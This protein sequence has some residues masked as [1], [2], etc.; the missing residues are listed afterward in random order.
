MIK[1]WI[2]ALLNISLVLHLQ[3]QS[4]PTIATCDGNQTI[5]L[6][7]STYDMCV[8]IEVKPGLPAPIERFEID[9]GD[10]SPITMIP[11]SNMPPETTHTFNFESFFQTCSAQE[12]STILLETFLENGDVVNNAFVAT[13][14]NPPTARF[15]PVQSTIC[16]GEEAVFTDSS[17]PTENLEILSWDY[18]DGSSGAE[19]THLYTAIGTY[20]V[21]LTVQNGCEVATTTRTIEVIEEAVAVALPLTGV[22]SVKNDTLIVCLG[23]GN[24]VMLDGDS[25]SLNELTHNWRTLSSGTTWVT[26]D[27]IPDPTIRFNQAG[28]FQIELMVNNNCDQPKRDTLIFNVVDAAGFTL[29]QQADEC[30]SLSYTPDPM[31]PNVTYLINGNITTN[32][33]VDLSIGEYIIEANNPDNLCGDKIKRDTF[34]I[35]APETAQINTPDTV[36]CSISDPIALSAQTIPGAQWQ[37]NGIVFDG[38]ID[39]A[40]LPSGQNIITY[41]LAPCIAEDTLLIEVLDVSIAF[42]GPAQFCLD[43][44]PQQLSATPAGGQWRGAGVSPDGIFD[45]TQI[46]E[47]LHTVYYDISHPT[48]SSCSNSDS[49][50]IL[51]SDLFVDFTTLDCNGTSLTFDTLLTS[52]FSE[53]EWSFGDG[54]TSNAVSP[55]H[56]FP[57]AQSY[58]VSLTI[59][60]NGCEATSSRTITIS[61]PPRPQFTLDYTG[62]CSPLAVTI[63]NASTG[64][65]LQ[66]SWDFGNG[67]SSDTADPGPLLLEAFGKDTVYQIQL[68]LSNDCA[69][70]IHTDS[71]QV[72]AQALARF[73]TAFNSYCSGD[74]IR[75]S[76]NSLGDPDFYQWVVNGQ[77]VGMD[78]LPPKFVHYTDTEENIEICQI[79]ENSCGRDTLCRTLLIRPTDVNSFF[80]VDQTEVCAG[81]SLRFTNFSNTNSVLYQFGDGNRTSELN[82]V[83]TYQ[84]PGDYRVVLQAYGCGSDSSFADIRVIPSPQA[85]FIAP[86]RLCPDQEFQ[87]ENSSD[88]SDFRWF[89]NDSLQSQLAQP[90]LK[91]DTPGLYQLRLAVSNLAGCVRTLSQDIEVVPLPDVQIEVDADSICAGNSVQ[92]SSMTNG[93]GCVWDFG[94]GSGSSDCNP[95]ISYD[96][97]GLQTIKLLVNSDLACRDSAI[98][99]IFVRSSPEVD[100]TFDSTMLCAPTDITF[101]NQTVEGE[102]FFWEFGDGSTSAAENPIHLYEDAGTYDVR[103]T[104][105]K[106]GICAVTLQKSITIA[107]IPTALISLNDSIGCHPFTGT[108]NIENPDDAI[109]YEWNFGDG[110]FAFETMTEHLYPSSGSYMVA[111]LLTNRS[112]GC[113]DTLFQEIEVNEIPAITEALSHNHCFED[114]T[115][116]ID[117]TISGG[118]APY[119]YNW[120]DGTTSEDR[121]DLSTGSYSLLITD[122]NGCSLRDT[123]IIHAPAELIP[124][125]VTD[126]PATCAGDEDG[127]LEISMSGGEGPYQLNWSNGSSGEVLTDAP[128]GSYELSIT[129]AI[130]CLKV[131]SFI[132]RE[133]PALQ[134]VDTVQPIRCFG[135]YAAIILRP[136]GGIGPYEAWLEP[137]MTILHGSNF[138]FD[139]LTGGAYQIQILDSMGCQIARD[140][141]IN[142]PS[143]VE[144]EILPTQEEVQLGD[145]LYLTIVHNVANP[146]ISWG[147]EVSEL[148]VS[149]PESPLLKPTDDRTYTVSIVNENGCTAS[150]EVSIRVIKDRQV[151][152]PNAFSPNG[153]SHNDEFRIFACQGVVRI[154]KV[155]IF[156][157][158]G[159]L[160]FE[161]S[162]IDPV[163]EVGT[164][165]WD[166][167]L[168]SRKVNSGVFVYKVT[169]EYIDGLEETY[170]GDVSLVR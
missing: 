66:Y 21:A 22:S 42:T 75:M 52:S 46:G 60:R 163:C 130:G 150:D 80:N 153:D 10:G 24:E 162:D 100:F 107:P 170:Y 69:T 138:R 145:S 92:L 142:V 65:N 117:L 32:F 164:K 136:G 51:V 38:T 167:R 143:P 111:L 14:K 109:Q 97:P 26:E 125:L 71:V 106:D 104:A 158:W 18:G 93:V 56:T 132:L 45:P 147:P 157:R 112:S 58:E 83:Y 89:I 87:P 105:E 151:Y 35:S 2:F 79:V 152:I 103:L 57:S 140:Y 155:Q 77:I 161:Q 33:P 40:T 7:A 119:Q 94:N 169:V 3:A 34:N 19:N 44:P 122:A 148:D 20:Q 39:A 76:N 124:D 72:R 49:L 133:N 82:P 64:D 67:Q 6:T 4:E 61:G 54:S 149:F 120:M 17:C 41:G 127:V 15:N 50:Q 31:L 84:A 55:T 166:G 160:V 25:L 48:D 116:S 37:L 86:A 156:S 96:T 114:Q 8:Q 5:C 12:R 99:S 30:I 115:G 90:N 131:Q 123:F 28:I 126:T 78:S 139:S 121:I 144:V 113:R 16:V 154:S 23:D 165:L 134:V 135:D 159:N 85:V 13:F 81:D 47:G 141:L 74:T 43:N 68:T 110:E 98:T 137:D 73:G 108:F 70:E 1:F 101:N 128:A 29:N 62:D 9:W 27:D 95:V 53:I 59:R 91:L 102:T 11:G 168:N 146:V 88:G 63:L 118:L 36:I 129:D